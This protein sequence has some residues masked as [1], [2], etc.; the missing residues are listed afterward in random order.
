[1][2]A[3]TVLAVLA[4]STAGGATGVQ[5]VPSSSQPTM[6]KATADPVPPVASETLAE[7]ILPKPFKIRTDGARRVLSRRGVFQPGASTGWHAHAGDFLAVVERGTLT[8][9]DE[10]CRRHELH[11]GESLYLPKGPPA[12]QS[13]YNLGHD[14]LVLYVMDILPVDAPGPNVDAPDPG[15]PAP[16]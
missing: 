3:L 16:R 12:A 5:A 1:M 7:G 8:W 15:C 2:S 14:E 13:G 11:A 6:V 9:I 10:K 4:L